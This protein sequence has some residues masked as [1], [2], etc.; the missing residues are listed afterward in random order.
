MGRKF[1]GNNWKVVIML[2]SLA[3]KKKKMLRPRS[4]V[5]SKNTENIK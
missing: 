2:V 5:I 4:L 3:K 1:V